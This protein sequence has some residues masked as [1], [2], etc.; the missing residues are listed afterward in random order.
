MWILTK[1]KFTRVPSSTDSTWSQND[2]WSF[3]NI[4]SKLINAEYDEN[5]SKSYATAYVWKRKW[6]KTLFHPA[7]EKTLLLIRS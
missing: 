3:R 5:Q 1:G 2:I 6:P 7:L 4:Y